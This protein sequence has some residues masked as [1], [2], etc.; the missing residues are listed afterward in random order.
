MFFKPAVHSKTTLNLFYIYIQRLIQLSYSIAWAIP[1][2]CVNAPLL[3][4]ET[5]AGPEMSLCCP[6]FKPAGAHNKSRRSV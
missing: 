3:Q 1:K 5:A 6:H 2:Q 4:G